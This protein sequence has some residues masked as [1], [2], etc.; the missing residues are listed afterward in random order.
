[1]IDER[2]LDEARAWL[3]RVLGGRIVS[4]RAQERWRPQYFA[5]VEKPQGETL[6]VLLRGWRAPGIVDT[7]PDSRKRLEREAAVLEA[8]QRLPVKAPRYY[9]FE[10]AG[11][12]ILMEAVPGDDQLT[13]VSDSS[14]QS[15]LFKDY[16]DD[17]VT[18]HA[19]DPTTLGLPDSFVA[20]ADGDANARANYGAHR[21]RYRAAG[22]GPDPLIELA[23]CWLDAHAPAVPKKWSLCTGDIGANQFM[24][25]AGGYRA[26]FDVEMAY[27]GDPLQDL[28]LMRYRNMCYP[29]ADFEAV[30]HHWFEASGR[31]FDS[32]SLQYWTM[33]G[34][35]GVMPTF[36]NLLPDP[37]PAIAGD[38]LLVWGMQCRRR[39]LTECL[40]QICGLPTPPVSGLPSSDDSADP[41]A[42][43]LAYLV[44][45]LGLRS[46]EHGE[47]LT[48]RIARANAAIA[49]RK[50]AHGAAFA[51]AD[52]DDL[53]RLTGEKHATLD[54]AR[55]RLVEL[56]RSDFEK[57]LAARLE[58]LARIEWRR[59]YI[60]EPA[61]HAVG[62]ASFHPLDTSC[63]SDQ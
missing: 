32:D 22:S 45:T 3:E 35:L 2:R 15:E 19:A 39:G 62:F 40:Q 10:P 53:C 44:E 47:D 34:L 51:G 18:I 48:L 36:W 7:I 56:I 49:L 30:L 55:A 23:W 28:G 38:M 27:I 59:E 8:L 52:L 54:A 11:G 58:A 6:S 24:F 31:P 29:V 37:D 25:G 16:I 5:E 12:W 4:W 14:R 41:V 13:A 17:F 60:L 46:A 1:V 9:G 50:A 43:H 61:I 57:D 42:R 21:A 26:L 20:P 33:V 63:G